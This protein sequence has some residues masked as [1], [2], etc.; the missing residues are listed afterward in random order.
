MAFCKKMLALIASC[1]LVQI[2]PVDALIKN[3]VL[4]ASEAKIM[5]VKSN[6]IAASRSYIIS[7]HIR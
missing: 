5:T 4:C 3:T 1:C 6:L 7:N 2:L